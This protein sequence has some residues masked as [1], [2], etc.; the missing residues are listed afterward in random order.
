MIFKGR[1]I[2]LIFETNNNSDL[3]IQL[4]HNYTDSCFYPNIKESIP[5]KRD[6]DEINNNNMKEYISRTNESQPI[7]KF[8]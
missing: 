1:K 3:G 4:E 5:I 2:L 8:I 7:N 6:F